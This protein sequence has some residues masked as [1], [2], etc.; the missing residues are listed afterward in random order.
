MAQF[1]VDLYAEK[2]EHIKLCTTIRQVEDELIQLRRQVNEPSPSSLPVPFTVDP[3][4]SAAFQDTCALG[5]AQIL[6]PSITITLKRTSSTTPKSRLPDQPPSL[7]T[8]RPSPSD[9]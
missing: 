7:T 3:H 1:F 5:N 6:K 8:S 2:S 9:L 4:C